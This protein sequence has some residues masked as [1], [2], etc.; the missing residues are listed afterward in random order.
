[1]SQT[2]DT[3]ELSIDELN[4]VS[5]GFTGRKA[6]GEQQEYLSTINS[7]EPTPKNWWDIW[8]GR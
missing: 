1:M 4:L 8:L 2:N 3:T 6:G 5:V 7:T